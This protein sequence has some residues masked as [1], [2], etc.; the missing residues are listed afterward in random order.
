MFRHAADAGAA[1]P[2]AVA[3]LRDEVLLIE[4]LAIMLSQGVEVARLERGAVTAPLEQAP[5]AADHLGAHAGERGAL[6]SFFLVVRPVFADQALA[7]F[8]HGLFQ[9]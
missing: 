1:L 3:H 5:P 2:A 7:L 9:I 8:F 6:F 4:I